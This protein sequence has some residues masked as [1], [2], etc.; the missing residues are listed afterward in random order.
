M[1]YKLQQIIGIRFSKEDIK[2][3]HRVCKKRGESVSSFIRRATK[4]EL[5]RMSYLTKA[6]KKALGMPETTNQ[7]NEVGR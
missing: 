4:K 5:A 2:L 6:E 7:K 1:N 3:L